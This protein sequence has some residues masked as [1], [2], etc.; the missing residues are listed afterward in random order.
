MKKALILLTALSLFSCGTIK[1]QKESTEVKT[2][3]DSTSKTSKETQIEGSK[4]TKISYK[5]NTFTFEPFD[6]TTPYFV[7]GKEYKNVI[8]KKKEETKDTFTIE[9]YKEKVF[10]LS[11]TITKLQQKLEQVKKDKETDNTGVYNR[12]MWLIII[13]FVIS[14]G[15]YH[16]TK[17]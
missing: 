13:L 8:V 16:F 3:I 4:E 12:F 15:Y 6:A 11:E 9:Q 10:E 1:K 5:S 7:D 17:K 14:L 2:E